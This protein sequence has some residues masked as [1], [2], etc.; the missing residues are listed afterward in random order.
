MRRLIYIPIIHGPEDFGTQLEAVRSAYV[1]RHGF[2][3]WQQHLKAIE[4]FWR[5]LRQ[6]VRALPE[7]ASALRIYQDGL[8]VCGRELDL[9]RQLAAQGSQN[10]R[11]LVDLVQEG[12]L[13]MG[14][15]DPEL[16]RQ[17]QQRSRGAA[18]LGEP[19]RGGRYD[20]LMEQ[21]DRYIAA[22]IDATLP[23]EGAVGLLFMGALHRVTEYLPKDIEVVP[24]SKK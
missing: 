6:A 10:H 11:L 8:P 9:V 12:A 18:A 19:A 4:Q 20:E 1:A 16:L 23:P 7:K 13:L 2:R 22:R 17:E 3:A 24:W 14:T 21:R 5:E 15:E